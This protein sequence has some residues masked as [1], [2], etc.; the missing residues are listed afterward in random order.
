MM[1]EK[2]MQLVDCELT[3]AKLTHSCVPCWFVPLEA[4][5]AQTILCALELADTQY[6]KGWMIY[7][8]GS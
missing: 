7:V 6:Q 8:Y 1:T 5:E 4:L 2:R 3:T